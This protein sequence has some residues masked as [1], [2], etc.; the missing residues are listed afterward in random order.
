MVAPNPLPFVHIFLRCQFIN[1]SDKG[2]NDQAKWQYL[3]V[4]LSLRPSGKWQQKS[5]LFL[6]RLS[7]G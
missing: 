2:Y 1:L 3:L 6:W 5:T 7:V 4:T